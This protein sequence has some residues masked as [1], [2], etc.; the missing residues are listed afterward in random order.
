M[1]IEP[2]GDGWT[3]SRVDGFK[4]RVGFSDGDPDP[5]FYDMCI[6]VATH[7]DVDEGSVSVI[8]TDA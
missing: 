7:K 6:E 8:I 3:K 5:N 1:A 4:A 2:A